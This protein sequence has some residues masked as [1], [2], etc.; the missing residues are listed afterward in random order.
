MLV[1]NFKFII[2]I[3]RVFV[4]FFRKIIFT[5]IINTKSKQTQSLTKEDKDMIGE[6]LSDLRK[7]KGLTQ[8]SGKH[9]ES[10]EA[11]YLGI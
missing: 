10:D 7:D 3:N 1:V 4:K 9:L 11:Q 2:R 6:R 8:E 5:I